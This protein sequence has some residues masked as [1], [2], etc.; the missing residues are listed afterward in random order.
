MTQ[1]D[2]QLPR[3]WLG[4]FGI[5]IDDLKALEAENERL[6]TLIARIAAGAEDPVGIAQRE[7]FSAGDERLT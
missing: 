7:L 4:S 1:V 2:L 5:S 6:R 3:G